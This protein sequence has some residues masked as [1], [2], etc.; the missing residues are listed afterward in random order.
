MVS[1]AELEFALRACAE[2]RRTKVIGVPDERLGEVVVLCAEPSAGAE[3]TEASLK[4]FLVERVSAYKV[5]RHVLLFEPGEMPS[6][7]SDTK[8]KDTE[9]IALAMARLGR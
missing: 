3:P 1:P 5:P 6:T 9:L 8:V 2:V 7:A 4:A